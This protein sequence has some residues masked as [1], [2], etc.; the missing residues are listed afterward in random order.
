MVMKTGDEMSK[1]KEYD[2]I[3]VGSGAGGSTV[4]REMTRRKKTVLLLERGGRVDMLGNLLTLPL[5]LNKF[6]I[7]LS[8]E[9][10]FVNFAET[11]GG[12]SNIA[13]G[14]AFPAPKSMFDPFGIDL[15]KETEEARKD[16][17]IQKLPDNLLG[18]ANVRLLEAAHDAGFNWDKLDNFIDAGKCEENCS[19]C[20]MGCPRGAK[21]TA[22]VYAD[23]AVQSGAELKL[24]TRVTRVLTENGRATGVETSGKMRYYGKAVVLSASISN[25]YL[26]RDAGIHD[27]GKGFCCDWLQFI[28]GVIPGVD[29]TR[30]N[31]MAVGSMEHYETDGFIIVPVFPHWSLFALL[32]AFMG[33]GYLAHF[34]DYWKISG[35]MV[36]IKDET[37]GELF[38]GTSFSKPI[39]R[40]DQQKLD[41]GLEIA[42]K[43]FKKAGAKDDSILAIKPLGAHPSCTC[44]IGDVLDSNL[45]T[46][47][48]NLY[49]CDASVLPSAMGAPLVWTLAA[50]GKRLAKHLDERLA[51]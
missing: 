43:V 6:G 18:K 30:D 4:A 19:K 11:Y 5:M 28:A 38:G 41:K 23:E 2:V 16:L 27:A 10:Y 31:P 17:W 15:T 34:P 29:S 46:K 33:P 36:K 8:K 40:A 26:L 48:R 37:R 44:R 42:K 12:A 9:G 32:L 3:V 22:R 25:A 39:T 49:C 35:I 20:M 13:A 21:W 1:T 7:T 45:E 24:H 51:H 50:L 14:A 47:V